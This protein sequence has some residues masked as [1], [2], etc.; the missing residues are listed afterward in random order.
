MNG[1]FF[2]L[3]YLIFADKHE[4]GTLLPVRKGVHKKSK[5]STSVNKIKIFLIYKQFYK[6]T[7]IKK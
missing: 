2:P 6:K 7:K 4:G 3:V 1:S 5:K